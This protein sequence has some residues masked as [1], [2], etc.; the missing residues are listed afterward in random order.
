MPES[1]HHADLCRQICTSS[2]G[3]VSSVIVAGCGLVGAWIGNRLH[4]SGFHVTMI[5]S[6]HTSFTSLDPDIERCHSRADGNLLSNLLSSKGQSIIVNALPGRIGH[7]FRIEA[8]ILGVSIIDV[9]FTPEDPRD[10]QDIAID[11]QTSIIF[12]TGVAPGFSNMLLAEAVRRHGALS[13]GVIKV[14]GN[15]TEPDDGWSYMAPFSPSDVIEEYTRP[16]RV[17]RDGSLFVLPALSERH[18]IDVADRGRMEAFLTDGL[19]SVLD[20]IPS[21]QLDEYTVRWP[22]HIDRY[23][24][25]KGH[26]DESSLLSA[27]SWNS[28]R[29]EFTWMEVSTKGA[30]GEIRWVVEAEGDTSGS[31]MARTTGAITCALVEWIERAELGPGIHSPET[32]PPDALAHCIDWYGKSGVTIT[33]EETF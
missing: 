14:G 9:S 10:L 8:C 27:W 16:A 29:P 23:L 31:S 13:S 2:S 22:G 32:L 5:D 3:N 17:L 4:Q 18:L 25:Q 1:G 15:P 26:M 28:Q 20:T 24:E 11:S 30:S 7:Q 6:N 19:R 12:D 21:V 33:C